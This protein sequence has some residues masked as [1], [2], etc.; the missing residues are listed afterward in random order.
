MLFSLKFFFYAASESLYMYKAVELHIAWSRMEGRFVKG[1]LPLV[2]ELINTQ[3]NLNNK[4][5]L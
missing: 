2:Y 1:K 4:T 5:S 3:T